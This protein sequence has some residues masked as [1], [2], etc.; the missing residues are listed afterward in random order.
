[1][2]AAFFLP[3]EFSPT[4]LL[5]C[6]GAAV[7]YLR[8]VVALARAGE[9][10]GWP[11]QLSFLLGVVLMYGV[12]QTQYDYMAQHMFF[13]HRLQ[14]LVLHHL[15]PFLI[16]VATPGAALAA[17]LPEP[18]R[19][20]LRKIGHWPPLYRTYRA[21]QQ[22]VVAAVL[23]VGLIYLWLLPSIHFYAMLNLPLYNVMNWSMAVDGLLFWYLML[24]PRTPAEG[25]VRLG[26]RI[27][28]LGLVIL[29]QNAIG[30]F[31]AMSHH[32]IYHVYA[33]C[34]RLWPISPLTDQRIGG[35][36]TWIPAAMMSVLGAI[37]VLR[38]WMREDNAARTPARAKEAPKDENHAYA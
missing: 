9:A 32:E 16:M 7:L 4:V 13:L 24:D 6:A 10:P 34:G 31:I 36:I 17:G 26:W 33:I 27:V 37:V 18:L 15:A 2:N 5:L 11:R 19:G 28:I 20:P 21:V 14:H 3:Y 29:P 23:F 35:L 8:G 30:G 25:G 12:L 22:P 38:R 1:M